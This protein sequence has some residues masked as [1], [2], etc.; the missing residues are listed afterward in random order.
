ML[1]P[2]IHRISGIRVRP[3]RCTK[4]QCFFHDS[5]AD[6]VGQVVIFLPPRVQVERSDPSSST[7]VLPVMLWQLSNFTMHE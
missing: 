7:R 3:Q 1:L 4:L 2:V 6:A 5:R